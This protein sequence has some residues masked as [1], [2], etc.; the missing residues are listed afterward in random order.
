MRDILLQ[1][2]YFLLLSFNVLAVTVGDEFLGLWTKVLLMPVL[3]VYAASAS[4][5]AGRRMAPVLAALALSWAG[6]MLLLVR[7]SEA[8]FLSGLGVFLAAHLV[9]IAHFLRLRSA[10][11]ITRR[12]SLPV[13]SL[14]VAYCALLLW[15][16]APK[17]GWMTLP[18]GAY[19][20]AISAMAASSVAASPE[21]GAKYARA[22][23]VGALLFLVS[24]S[25][26]A[27]SRFASPIEFAP[28]LIMLT[29]GLGQ[30]MIAEGAVIAARELGGRE[31]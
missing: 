25:L 3:A 7:G 14:I 21:G 30:F 22:G 31:A 29:Y 24:D 11:G 6:D 26:L 18:V 9:Y 4:Q 28:T 5:G 13:L 27:V 8:F 15:V 23:S 20:L 1:T 12:P 19:G 2:L 17:M 10:A 16:L